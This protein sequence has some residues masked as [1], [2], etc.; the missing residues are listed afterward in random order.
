[1]TAQDLLSDAGVSILDDFMQPHWPDVT[2]AVNL[3]YSR[4]VPRVKPLLY[5]CHKLLFVGYG[6]HA[7]F[8]QGCLAH[9]GKV[10]I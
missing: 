6:W 1:M 3:F 5:C 4:S 2:E 8:L 7:A 10:R 9:S